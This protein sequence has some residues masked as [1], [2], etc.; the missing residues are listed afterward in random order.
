MP[1]IKPPSVVI[2]GD[3][4]KD[5]AMPPLPEET[6]VVEVEDH[7]SEQDTFAQ[8]QSELETPSEPLQPEQTEIDN[9]LVQEP[10]EEVKPD[11]K[12]QNFSA[13]REKSERIERERDELAR[14][15]KQIQS[16]I[17]PKV[18][19]EQP[20]EDLSLDPDDFVEGKHLK[21]LQ[22]QIL[23]LQKQ[24]AAQN[25]VS[26]E[27]AIEARLKAQYA[28]FNKVVTAQTLG[29]LHNTH[30]EIAATINSSTDLYNKA[31]SAYTIIKK[32]GIYVEDNFAKDRSRAQINASKPK[33]LAS[34]SPQ[35]G[36]TPLSKANAFANGLTEELKEQ[37]RREMAEA[38]KYR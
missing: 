4:N 10:S 38:S 15:L 23:D 32:L 20:I 14:T 37:M 33:P 29:S 22:K 13:L 21:K 19:E 27:V 18:Q 35:Q 34:V 24:T 3:G 26:Q 28:D 9:Q 8:Q 11:S 12:E 6:P 36:D 2:P 7:L 5:I 16:S 31:V 30:P 25:K 1:A 17:T